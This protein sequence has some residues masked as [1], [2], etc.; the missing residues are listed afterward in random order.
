MP[1]VTK[2]PSGSYRVQVYI[3]KD[4]NGKRKYKSF[5]GAD[6]K[7]VSM[8]AL[9]FQIH[10]KDVTRDSAQM[11]VGEA[12]EQYLA[13]KSNVLSPSTIRAYESI[14]KHRLKGLI[15]RR[16]CALNNLI[17]QQAVNEEAEKLSP[18]TVRNV[19]GFLSAVLNEYYSEL[20]LK[21]ALPQKKKF[22][23]TILTGSQIAA[24]IQ[25]IQ[26]DEAEIAILCALW[27][28]MRRSEIVGLKWDCVDFK[29][30]A[31]T[32]RQS[33]VYDKNGNL[34]EKGTK[35]YSSYRTIS[36]PSYIMERLKTVPRENEFV[37]TMSPDNIRKHLQ[38]ILLSIGLPRIRLHDLRHSNASV[39]LSLNVPDK[40]AMERGGWASNQTMKKIYQ[41]TID[42]QKREV[43]DSINRYFEML[44]YGGMQHEMQHDKK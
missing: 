20:H 2:L 32:I 7:K 44:V 34:V 39:M 23:G 21:I 19:F 13:S 38:R 33:R 10:H 40:Y 18:K 8:A 16:L 9:E 29:S 14:R 12:M 5:T 26:G 30:G 31:I 22:E 35:T 1:K 11:T 17:I 36:A 28:G 3:G 41:H 4:S 43:D 6:P 27:L 24:L 37:V 42:E 15:N 25:A